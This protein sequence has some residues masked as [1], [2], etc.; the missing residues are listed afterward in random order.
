MDCAKFTW[1]FRKIIRFMSDVNKHEFS[2]H[3]FEKN[4]SPSNLWK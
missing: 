2:Q 3:I 1:V 4:N